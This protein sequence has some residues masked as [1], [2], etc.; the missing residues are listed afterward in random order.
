MDFTLADVFRVAVDAVCLDF[1]AE[2]GEDVLVGTNGEFYACSNPLI[3]HF[4]EIR[5]IL[6]H[7]GTCRPVSKTISA[8]CNGDTMA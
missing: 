5:A 7:I 2:G 8:S 6:I 1:F 3:S 4:S